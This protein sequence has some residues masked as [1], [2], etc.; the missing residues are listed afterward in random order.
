MRRQ[1]CFFSPLIECESFLCVCLSQSFS[2]FIFCPTA[3]GT[4]NKLCFSELMFLFSRWLI[5]CEE[6]LNET[7]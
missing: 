3:T 5:S 2:A 1:N 4:E 6:S 7:L